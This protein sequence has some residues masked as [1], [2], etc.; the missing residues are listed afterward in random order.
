[1]EARL[2]ADAA[3]VGAERPTNGAGALDAAAL[4]GAALDHCLGAAGLACL[5]RQVEVVEPVGGALRL[6]AAVGKDEGGV[7][8]L[9]AVHDLGDDGWPHAAPGQ[10]AEIIDGGDHLQVHGLGHAGVDDGDGAGGIA[11]WGLGF[12]A[13]EEAGDFV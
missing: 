10:V 6:A 9:D 7:V 4:D 11:Y 2:A 12:V 3:V 13:A 1:L 5:A 8:G